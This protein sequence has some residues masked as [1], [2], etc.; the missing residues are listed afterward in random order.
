MEI[1]ADVCFLGCYLWP[2][3]HR[4]DRCDCSGL[5][6]IQS[7]Q[8]DR[9]DVCTIDCFPPCP[10]R[11]NGMALISRYWISFRNELFSLIKIPYALLDCISV[12]KAL[13]S[14]D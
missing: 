6:V 7:P 11:P 9:L 13:A 5:S 14:R 12:A 8:R 2:A 1:F 4:K 10:S 3:P